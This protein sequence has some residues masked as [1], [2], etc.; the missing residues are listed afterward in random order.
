ML[1]SLTALKLIEQLVNLILQVSDN[2][3]EPGDLR[4]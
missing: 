2:Q 1:C 3:A 4:D